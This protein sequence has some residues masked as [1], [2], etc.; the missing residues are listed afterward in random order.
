[1]G[2]VSILADYVNKAMNNFTQGFAQLCPRLWVFM[3]KII[4]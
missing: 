3:P 2:H 1:M 4:G